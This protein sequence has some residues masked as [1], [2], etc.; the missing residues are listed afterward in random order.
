ME[1]TRDS[2]TTTLRISAWFFLS[3]VLINSLV[4][5]KLPET[6]IEHP[7]KIL[8]FAVYALLTLLFL[9]AYDKT[10]I[11]IIITALFIFGAGLE[12][13]QQVIPYRTGSFFDGVANGLGIIVST[14]LQLIRSRANYG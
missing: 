9:R 1:I 14:G 5:V 7:D 8:H 3:L 12:T 4:P 13:I 11:L 10:P 2:Q 6:G